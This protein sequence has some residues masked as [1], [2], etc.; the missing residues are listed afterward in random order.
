MPHSR[1]ITLAD[2]Q[3]HCGFAEAWLPYPTLGPRAASICNIASLCGR[4]KRKMANQEL[5]DVC[6]LC[7]S[8]ASTNHTATP[9]FNS[10]G[11]ENAPTGREIEGKKI[12]TFYH[13]I[14]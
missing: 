11:V 1:E 13:V 7:F 8:L 6:H 5:E 4:W 12:V 10:T 14:V 9:E 2:I 3:G